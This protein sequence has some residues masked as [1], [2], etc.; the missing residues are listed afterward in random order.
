MSGESAQLHA[1]V[2][3]NP[4][5]FAWS[6]QTALLSPQSL[7]SSTIPLAQ[8]T[9]FNL[10]VRDPN[11]CTASKELVVK[12]LY[13]LYM[14]S[15]FTANKDGK[16]DV[17]RIPPGASLALHEFS[18]FDRW[19]NVVFTTTDITKGWNGTY[20]GQNLATGTYIYLINGSVQDKEVTLKGTVIL[21]R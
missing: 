17:F 12:V 6:P 9:V 14:P 19:G 1:S 3:G 5:S 18:V 16:N 8:D 11:G 10:T 21:L 20:H 15:A 13:K 4:V 2:S 7:T